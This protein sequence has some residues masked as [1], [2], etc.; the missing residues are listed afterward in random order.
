MRSSLEATGTAGRSTLADLQ[1]TT[2]AFGPC[3]DRN[4]VSTVELGEMKTALEAALTVAVT[5]TIKAKPGNPVLYL[6]HRLI[7]YAQLPPVVPEPEK[8]KPPP[9]AAAAPPGGRP[10]RRNSKAWAPKQQLAQD[11]KTN[12]E[13][14]AKLDIYS[15]VPRPRRLPY[16]D[17]SRGRESHWRRRSRACAGAPAGGDLA[18]VLRHLHHRTQGAPVPVRCV[19]RP[20]RDRSVV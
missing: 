16:P 3:A 15:Q 11:A 2:D 14:Q 7:Q 13:H 18:P 1:S 5:E 17:R 8:A 19:V 9:V 6:A 4:M 12:M 20:A 10:K